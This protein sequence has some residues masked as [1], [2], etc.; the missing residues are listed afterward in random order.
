MFCE[1]FTSPVPAIGEWNRS[2]TVWL[3]CS[4]WEENDRRG[5]QGPNPSDHCKSRDFIPGAV[6]SHWGDLNNG[7]LSYFWHFKKIIHPMGARAEVGRL[8]RG[9]ERGCPRH[10]RWRYILE[11]ETRL[12][13]VTEWREWGT[14]RKSQWLLISGLSWVDG[15]IVYWNRKDWRKSKLEERV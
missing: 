15:G 2:Q 7:A 6:G 12:P 4:K 13:D 3:E 11:I 10:V 5:K 14:R 8:G 9:S 1:P